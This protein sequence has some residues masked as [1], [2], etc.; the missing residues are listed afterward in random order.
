[1]GHRE[2]IMTLNLIQMMLREIRR[3]RMQFALGAL[4]VLVA[5]AVTG[6][7]LGLL[8]RHDRQ[9]EA[10]LGGKQKE[11]EE[12][13]LDLHAD[14]A[15]AMEHLGF[16]IVILPAEQQIGDWY[17]DQYAK[18]TMAESGVQKLRSAGLLTLEQLVP[19]LQQKAVWPETRW[20]VLIEGNGGPEAPPP[21]EVDIGDEIARG[22]HLKPGDPLVLMGRSFT[23]RKSIRMQASAEDLKIILPLGTAQELLNQEGRINEIRALQCRGAWQEINRI[24]TEV[25]RILPGTQIIEKGSDVLTRVTAIRQVEQKGA[26]LIAGEEAARRQMR[27]TFLRTLG[28]VMPLLLT[29]CTVWIWM[30]ASDHAAR[31]SAEIGILRAVG[32]SAGSITAL[33]MLRSAL[34]GLIGGAGGVLI[35]ALA[36]RGMNRAHGLILLPLAL[37]IALAGSFPPVRRAAGRDP[38]EILRGTP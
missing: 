14:T 12:R 5:T 10:L 24:R 17:A 6:G 37:L 25:Q 27:S 16:N 15:R 18:K 13:I 8:D 36:A 21:G 22:L 7:A 23:V 4:S 30:L 29:G 35:S 28:L 38:A 19:A 33:F 31:R 11:L 34:F 1:M 20:T 32:F 9:T 3:R 26:E 2:K